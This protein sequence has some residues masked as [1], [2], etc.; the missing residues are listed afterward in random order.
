MF[1][2]K[3]AIGFP[4]F[5]RKYAGAIGIRIIIPYVSLESSLEKISV[6]PY[7]PCNQIRSGIKL[8]Q[9][10]EETAVEKPLKMQGKHIEQD[11]SSW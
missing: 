1:H 9:T 7:G 5:P 10:V 6:F 8:H 3:C 4:P 11:S 2:I